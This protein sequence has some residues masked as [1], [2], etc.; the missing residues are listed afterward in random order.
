MWLIC[1]CNDQACTDIFLSTSSKPHTSK[2]PAPPCSSHCCCKEAESI[3]SLVAGLQLRTKRPILSAPAFVKLHKY[4]CCCICCRDAG[5]IS[6]LVA[7]L[8]PG[9]E[10]PSDLLKA[11]L[12]VLLGLA[13]DELS[14]D[15][16]QQ[17]SGI[18]R[19]IKLLEYAKDDQVSFTV[20]LQ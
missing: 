10:L 11:V 12:K 19:I 9:V 13:H 18:P 15:A 7:L 20:G 16:I 8:Q 1:H 2:P 3:C 5:A 17:A 4:T 6:S 14:C